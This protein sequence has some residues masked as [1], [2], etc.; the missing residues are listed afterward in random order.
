M[1][2]KKPASLSSDLLARKGEAQPFSI[3]PSERMT[4]YLSAEHGGSHFGGPQFDSSSHSSEERAFPPEPEI[5]FTPEEL[6]EGSGRG[7]LIAMALL[8][9]LILGGVVFAVAF[10]GDRGVAPV[11]TNLPTQ[12]PETSAP[13]SSELRSSV[14]P[15]TQADTTTQTSD[16]GIVLPSPKTD[17]PP[18]AE[19]P[20]AKDA[21]PVMDAAPAEPVTITKAEPAPPPA[22][23]AKKVEA[24]PVV[25]GQGAYVVQLLALRD[26]AATQTAWAGLQKKYP[27]LNAHA[28][29]IERADLGDKGIYYRLRAAGFTSRSEAQSFCAKL[30]AAGQDCM[31]KAR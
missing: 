2:D 22:A 19:T 27:S 16:A 15:T 31:A 7:R 24:K 30:K 4:P 8:G 23:V 26:E 25:S 12:T 17:A 13:V 28:M 1:N 14:P 20:A 11:A 10:Q 21:A 3:D 6:E 9:A 5:I 29:D 18:I